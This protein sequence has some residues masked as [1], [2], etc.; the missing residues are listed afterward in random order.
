MGIQ[1]WDT[2]SAKVNMV[3]VD[4]K[5]K[6]SQLTSDVKDKAGQLTS[7]VKE[8]VSQITVD[9]VINTLHKVGDFSREVND[10]NM[11][12]FKER[13][14]EV[15][16]NTILRNMNNA[17]TEEGRRLCRDEARRRGLI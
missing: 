16:D 1:L 13:L 5:I 10:S 6:A 8:K 11:K 15:P 12:S 17:G 14:K 2:I 9:D 3:K 4:V 7:D